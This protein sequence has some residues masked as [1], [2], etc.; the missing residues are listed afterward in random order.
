MTATFNPNREGTKEFR[1]SHLRNH[2]RATL[3]EAGLDKLNIRTAPT[4][5]GFHTQIMSAG[6]GMDSG[7]VAQ[8][9]RDAGMEL[10]EA[11]DIAVIVTHNLPVNQASALWT[12]HEAQVVAGLDHYALTAMMGY[13]A[14]EVG[15]SRCLDRESQMWRADAVR[16]AMTSPRVRQVVGRWTDR[17]PSWAK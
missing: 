9:L 11:T 13:H 6:Q 17:L 5:T 8:V 14:Q 16:E 12:T 7:R 1:E 15:M 10:G 4:A 3:A 2:I